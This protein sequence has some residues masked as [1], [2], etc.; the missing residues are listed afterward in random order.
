MSASTSLKYVIVK[1]DN[2]KLIPIDCPVC[3]FFMLKDDDIQYY[4]EYSEEFHI[5]FLFHH[6]KPL[7][8][9]LHLCVRG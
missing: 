6:G 7:H 5:A 4:N 1:P 2:F 8:H 3:E 9:I